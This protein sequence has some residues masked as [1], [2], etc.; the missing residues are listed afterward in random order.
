MSR[1]LDFAG[2]EWST[3]QSLGEEVLVERLTPW[4]ERYPNVRVRPI[5]VCDGRLTSWSSRRSPPSSS[6]WA[7]MAESD[8]RECL[9]VRSAR[10]W[11]NSA[12][13]PVIVARHS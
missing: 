5:V 13:M 9:S 12:R 11:L 4:Q 10:R 7:V 6:S 1:S 2:V 8:S 3:M